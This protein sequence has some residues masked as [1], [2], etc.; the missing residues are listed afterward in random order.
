M[1]W[2]IWRIVRDSNYY[3]YFGLDSNS[4]GILQ[5]DIGYYPKKAEIYNRYGVTPFVPLQ[6]INNYNTE[7][8]TKRIVNAFKLS[9]AV[10]ELLI[11][12][13]CYH[14]FTSNSL[15]TLITEELFLNFLDHSLSSS[16]KGF[17]SFASMSI[18]FR[19]RLSDKKRP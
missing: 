2:E 6:F 8:V 4:I 3:K 19:D 18:S 17:N 5:K 9:N 10:K 14:P 12:N 1:V 7:E 13:N 16:F 15:S 11:K